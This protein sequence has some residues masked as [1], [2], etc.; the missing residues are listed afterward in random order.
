MNIANIITLSRLIPVPFIF[1]FMESNPAIALILFVTS[2]GLDLIDGMV[3]RKL[4]T[5]SRM[6]IFLDPMVDKITINSIL[7]YLSVVNIIP[8]WMTI[9]NIV[10]EFA[11]QAIRSIAPC[12]GI[13]LKTGMLN[14]SKLVLQTLTILLVFAYLLG[15]PYTK[16][17]YVY[18][19]GFTLFIAYLS[20][21]TLLYSNR[22]IFNKP[23]TN[24]KIKSDYD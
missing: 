20:M 14:K 17:T 19:M 24:I 13:V 4:K 6:G 1:L 12:K 15:V 10:R 16:G 18:M 7:I 22:E 11:V 21:T 23:E 3:A 9:L 5:E 8:Y 2:M